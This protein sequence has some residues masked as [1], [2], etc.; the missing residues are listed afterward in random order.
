MEQETFEAFVA[1]GKREADRRA[2]SGYV[3]N[4]EGA[5]IIIAHVIAAMVSGKNW[6]KK[7]GP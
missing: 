4:N 3:S 1:I 6:S 7:W 5:I 2:K